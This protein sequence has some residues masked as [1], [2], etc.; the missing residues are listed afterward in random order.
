MKPGYRVKKVVDV[1][2]REGGEHAILGIV[3]GPD[4]SGP[5]RWIGRKAGLEDLQAAD[6]AAAQSS[7]APTMASPSQDA[8]DYL[9]QTM[10]CFDAIHE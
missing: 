9:N 2:T 7:T 1:R 8:I 4:V 6:A 10:A 3:E 5:A